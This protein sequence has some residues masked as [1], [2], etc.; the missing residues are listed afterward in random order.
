[1]QYIYLLIFIDQILN[2][3]NFYIIILDKKNLAL[4]NN[5]TNKLYIILKGGKQIHF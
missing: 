2:T 4:L 5:N 3:Y 1:M